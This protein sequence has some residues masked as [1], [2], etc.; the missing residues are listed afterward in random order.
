MKK[1]KS[2]IVDDM[3]KAH[4]RRKGAVLIE[5]AKWCGKT[6]TAEQHASSVLYMADPEVARVADVS[7]KR[8]L[9]GERPRLLDEWQVACCP[10]QL[11]SQLKSHININQRRYGEGQYESNA[12]GI[13]SLLDGAVHFPVTNFS[14]ASNFSRSRG[15]ALISSRLPCWSNSLYVGNEFTLR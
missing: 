6:T 14:N 9:K 4:L 13:K 2:R 5:G 10:N 1:Y 8:L 12:I 15:S 11:S 7:I 3:L